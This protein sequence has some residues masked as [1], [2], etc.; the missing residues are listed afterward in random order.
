MQTESSLPGTKTMTEF[1]PFRGYRYDGSRV[2]V[3]NVIAPPYDVISET[4]QQ[5]LYSRDPFNCIRLILNRITE[6]DT[7]TD[8]RYTRA[9]DCF[10]SWK[11]QGILTRETAESFYVYRQTFADPV[12]GQ[13]RVRSAVLG[14]L[15]LEP[16]EKGVVIPHEKTLAKPRADRES[17]M[18]ATRA[19]LSPVFGLYEDPAGEVTGILD[20]ASSGAP[21]FDVTDDEGVQHALWTLSD[22]SSVEAVTEAM[23][24]R[25]VYIADGHHRYTTAL[26]NAGD[27]RRR[28]GAAADEVLPSDYVLMALVEFHDPGLAL[29]PTHR[30]LRGLHGFNPEEAVKNLESA[31][32][33]REAGPEEVKKALGQ[34]PA[35]RTAIGLLFPGK[36]ARILTV[37]DPG[38]IRAKM[39]A[40]HS[41]PWYSLDV[42]VLAHYI[43]GHLWGITE[44]RWESVLS[45]THDDET[46]MQAL[47]NNETDAVFFLRKPRVEIL[48]EM[49]KTGELLPQKSTY[50]YPKLASGLVF[51]SHE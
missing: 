31:F 1:R 21:L 5:T 24:S 23:R 50:F 51:Y 39:P 49:G 11:K 45:F 3:K 47:D 48:S 28:L 20:K 15:R 46:A 27:E 26:K 43:M 42:T 44:D 14:R 10:H 37:K 18:K 13:T 16:F 29:F 34:V 8:N 17:L 36:I 12:D 7:E 19:N 38:T 40:G 4:H 33:V 41:A 22:A 25:K 9:R 6:I 35:G 30:I 32:E 2:T